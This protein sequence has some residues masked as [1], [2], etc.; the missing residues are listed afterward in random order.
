MLEAVAAQLRDRMVREQIAGRGITDA[1]VLDVLRQVPRHR[2]VSEALANEAYA[3]HPLAIGEDQTISQPYMV[4]LMTALLALRP[5]DRVLE[6][7][8]GSG[9]QTA[10]LAALAHSILSIE[11]HPPLAASAAQ[12]LQSLG[13]DNITIRCADGTFGAE[14]AAPFDAILVT[15]G[16]PE[17]P[18][19][20]QQQLAEGGRLVCPI[21]DRTLQ[22]LVRITRHGNRFETTRTIQ[23]TFVPLVGEYGWPGE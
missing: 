19:L 2:F 10:V 9:Y 12:R 6:I 4:A 3:D 23:C 5:T 7:G 17:V 8:T 16:G 20:L 14:D 11:R 18:P 1:A 21:G 13:Y 22:T 15:A